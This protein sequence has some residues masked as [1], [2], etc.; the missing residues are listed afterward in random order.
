MKTKNTAA[1]RR[2]ATPPATPN[3]A[4]Y[5]GG[6]PTSPSVDELFTAIG[7][8]EYTTAVL[9]AAHID[10]AGN[11][12]MN[13]DQITDDGGFMDSALPWAKLVNG[14]R[15]GCITRIEL[16]IGGDNSS[17]A[18][19]RRL[20]RQHG[21]GPANPLYASFQALIA[22]IP[23]DAINYDDESEYDQESSVQ[24]ALICAA[25]GMRISICPYTMQTYWTDLITAINQQK[26]GLVDA[27]YLQCYGGGAA[28]DPA[29]WNQ[30][31]AQNRLAV[32][33]GLWATHFEGHT[34]TCTVQ[35]TDAQA[36]LQMQSWAEV[37]TLAGG[38]MFSGT[39]MMNCKSG[40]TPA[41][42]AAAILAGIDAG[43]RLQGKG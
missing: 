31:F 8:G 10:V 21:A 41:S 13:D 43:T 1:T 15:G 4:I 25:L 32:G 14:L 26:P 3:I 39:D 23:I 34:S 16:S 18:N 6:N 37:S 24:F 30:A 40:G 20:I 19:I 38:W 22:A 9:W 12:H 33:P 11:I 36:Q 2:L 7:V 42:Y 17:F 29:L 28:N 27:V 5:T 35:T